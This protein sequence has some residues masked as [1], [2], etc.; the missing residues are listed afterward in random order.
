[1]TT[2]F[3]QFFDHETCSFSYLIGE[4]GKEALIIDPVFDKFNLYNQTI[5]ELNLHL[6]FSIDTHTHADHITCA[7]QLH[8]K[9]GSQTV[10][11]MQSI[12]DNVHLKL[13]ENEVIKVNDQK[14]KAI[15]T[16]GHTYDSYSYYFEDK[17][18][19]GDV[20]LIRATGRT[21]FQN[22]H[23]KQSYDSIFNKLLKLPENTLLYPAHDY[24]GR[25]V[26]TLYEERKFNPRLQVKSCEEYCLIMDNLNLPYP[27]FMDKAL[28]A[29]LKAGKIDEK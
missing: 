4:K 2:I 6:V 28:P 11:G 3:R 9:L 22:G 15:Y 21:D 29:N 5:Q 14:F 7:Y 12:C 20:L 8:Q 17:I 1:M 27:K 19:A 10:N 25:T 16:P 24:N 13:K 26:S 23:S 18:F